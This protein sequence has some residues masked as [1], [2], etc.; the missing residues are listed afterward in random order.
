MGE[1]VVDRQPVLKEDSTTQAKGAS[2]YLR[3]VPA[4]PTRQVEAERGGSH[5]TK[6]GV[7]VVR[8]LFPPAQLAKGA[9]DPVA[10]AGTKPWPGSKMVVPRR[11]QG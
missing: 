6:S 9:Q 8:Q 5:L 10:H 7:A 1:L 11:A 3:K 4:F 2:V